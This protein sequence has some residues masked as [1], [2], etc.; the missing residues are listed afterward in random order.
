MEEF[1]HSETGVWQVCLQQNIIF[2]QLSEVIDHSNW[3]INHFFD[4]PRKNLDHFGDT[5]WLCECFVEYTDRDVALPSVPYKVVEEPYEATEDRCL[6]TCINDEVRENATFA[7]FR[8]A[9]PWCM[10]LPE[11]EMSLH[12]SFTMNSTQG[13]PSTRHT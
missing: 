9:K 6:A 13:R 3:I 8:I 1:I 4:K 7:S 10:G 2:E 11:A 12:V 5:C